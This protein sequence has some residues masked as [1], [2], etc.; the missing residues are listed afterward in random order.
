M[1]RC[2]IRLLTDLAGVC[3]RPV[4]RPFLLYVKYEPT[5]K[6]LRI[7]QLSPISYDFLL[8]VKCIA[9]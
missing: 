2:R 1:S 3:S 4:T 5:I 8:Y 9:Q 6:M 7:L